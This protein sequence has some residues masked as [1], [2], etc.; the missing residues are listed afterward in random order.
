[1]D[2][3]LEKLNAQ[4][5][6]A[7]THETG[8]LLIVA[9]AGT[10]KTTVLINRLAYLIMEKKVATENILLITFTEKA[11]S[12]LEERADQILPYGY[13]DLWIHTF[14]G[15]AERLLREHALDIGLPADFKLMSSTEQ[16]ILVKKNL[17]AFKLDYYRPLGNPTKFISE[18]LRHFSRLKD[19]NVS[20]EEYSAYVARLEKADSEEVID[21]IELKRLKELANAYGVYNNLLLQESALDFGD[22]IVYCLKLLKE[23]PKILEFYRQQF[24]YVMVDE[25]QDTNWAQY[26]LVK[27]LSAP[28]NNLV[29]VGD[30]DQSVYKF[31]G[32]SI[33]NILQFKDDFPKAEEAILTENYRSR[34]EILD[35]AYRFIQNNNPNRLEEKLKIDKSLKSMVLSD[36]NETSVRFLQFQRQEEELSFVVEEIA[37]RYV[38]SWK[39]FAILVRANDTADVFVKEL[40]RRGIP[41]QFVSLRGLYY[42]PLIID[43]LSYLRL[44]DNYHE[45]GAL[46]RVLNMDIFRV[47]QSDLITINK[48]AHKKV[49]SLFEAL[50]LASDIP[51]LADKSRENI[52]KL[53]SLISEHSELA[54]NEK[55]SRVFVQFVYDSGLLRDLDHDRDQEAFSYLNQIYRKI[56][57]FEENL[58]D[59]R[60]KDFLEI[61]ELELAAGETGALKLDFADDDSVK[62]MTVHAAKGLEFKHVFVVNAVDK[63]FPT[64]SRSE[65]I[66][67]PDALVKEKVVTSKD[68]HTEEERRLFYVALTR[69]KENL[70]ITG[71]KN[72]GGVRDKKPSRFISEMDLMVTEVNFDESFSKKLELLRDLENIGESENI[73]DEPLILP[74]QFSFSQLAAFSNC[75]LQYKFAFILK[76]PA[77][78]DKPSLIFGRVMHSVLFDFLSPLTAGKQALQNSL[79]GEEGAVSLSENKLLEIFEERWQPDGYSDKEQRSEYHNKGKEAL[80]AFWKYWQELGGRE[81]LF[82]E[83]RFSFKIG[84]EIMKGAIDRVDVLPDGRLEIVDYKTGNPKEKL[85]Y[86]ARRQLILYQLFLEAFLGKSIA[87]LSYYYLENGSIMS[88][89]ATDKEKEKLQKEIEEEIGDIKK[90][91]F[92]PKPS[93]MCKFCDFKGICEFAKI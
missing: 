15:F 19:E 83:K 67:L 70:F 23:R 61:L 39:D 63:K 57:T 72:Y 58:P 76:I 92:P 51:G 84:G 18:L 60:L 88:F 12:E 10:G 7:V 22:L 31:R 24:E 43:C 36:P 33:S 27:L 81:I 28:K 17:S 66:S 1:M 87:R 54:V 78:E 79:F 68:A 62:I 46:F 52:G 82:L 21:E 4:Q 9:G 38:D 77:P 49:Y 11:A 89:E 45:S 90:G 16:W 44:L 5:K 86:E 71:A 85:D 73:K 14:H 29:V 26:E 13:V 41:N 64:I 53:L 40:N 91:K 32:A 3:S 80:R 74:E 35:Y 48:F 20:A 34:Q 37:S 2:F 47:S 75:P 56:K 50:S 25:F 6:K 93:E 42:K 55:P 8:P 65:K 59:A 30:D 69:A